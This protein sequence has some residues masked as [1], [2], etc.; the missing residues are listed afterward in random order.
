MILWIFAFGLMAVLGLIGYYQGAIRV[1]F[2]LIGLIVAA[3]LAM[4]LAG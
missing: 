4:P 2:S 1:A 3:F